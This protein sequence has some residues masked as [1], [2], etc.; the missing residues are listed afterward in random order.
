MDVRLNV[1]DAEYFYKLFTAV[2]ALSLR[3]RLFLLRRARN[4]RNK[5]SRLQG[6]K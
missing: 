4:K 5:L 1:Q 2:E 6:Q 3:G